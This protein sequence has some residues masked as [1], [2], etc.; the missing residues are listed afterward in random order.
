MAHPLS[1][2]VMAL[3]Q[4]HAAAF[5]RDRG[6]TL[7]ERAWLADFLAAAGPLGECWTSVA[8]PACR[9]PAT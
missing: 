3:Y 4:A 6:N 5:E 8:A 2:G 9:S 7:I 1:A